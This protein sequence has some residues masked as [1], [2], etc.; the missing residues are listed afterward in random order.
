M[1]ALGIG[2]GF[3]FV[4][5]CLRWIAPV[6]PK[7]LAWAGMGF[8]LTLIA[9]SLLGHPLDAAALAG[10]ASAVV[11]ALC[12]ALYGMWRRGNMGSD[13]DDEDGPRPPQGGPVA[14]WIK[15]GKNIRT[16]RN[17]MIG[18]D[19][20][21]VDIGG[22]DNEHRENTIIP[23]RGSAPE[24]DPQNRHARRADKARR[25]GKPED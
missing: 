3:S 13:G 17:T 10:L 23:P 8:G 21:I 12:S 24:A 18:F 7:P 6:I 25:R 4:F 15:D 22:T 20:G 2:I 5:A 14:I 11:F 16:F 9:G 19:R 1:D